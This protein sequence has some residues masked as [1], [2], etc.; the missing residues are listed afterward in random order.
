LRLISHSFRK[1]LFTAPSPLFLELPC[2]DD[3]G[4]IQSCYRRIAG[5][6]ALT[7]PK[8]SVVASEIGV[9]FFDFLRQPRITR[10]HQLH[11]SF[12]FKLSSIIN[13]ACTST[14]VLDLTFR[15]NV[16]AVLLLLAL[17]QHPPVHNKPVPHQRHQTSQHVLLNHL[18]QPMLPVLHPLPSHL[19]EVG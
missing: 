13:H 8:K 12:I 2:A 6:F 10:E 3:R 11:F 7:S 17:H 19:R 16:V 5:G 14:F 18:L 4:S 9:C 15:D 1:G